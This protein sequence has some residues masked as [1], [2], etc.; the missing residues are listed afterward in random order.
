MMFSVSRI[1]GIPHLIRRQ[2]FAQ[3]INVPMAS[4]GTFA[5]M[6]DPG[7]YTSRT[8]GTAHVDIITGL[9]IEGTQFS[10]DKALF[11]FGR[12]NQRICTGARVHAGN[13]D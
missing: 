2:V 5:V 1:V 7:F 3:V 6:S 11:L 12:E 8:E 13:D 9:E 4:P 10:D